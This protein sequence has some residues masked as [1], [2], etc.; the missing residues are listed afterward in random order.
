MV[1]MEKGQIPHPAPPL[2]LQKPPKPEPRQP[3]MISVED[4]DFC[5]GAHQVL[6]G[7]FCGSDVRILQ[8][9]I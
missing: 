6:F 2:E 9:K 7:R 5:Y 4:V 3:V 1:V 8:L